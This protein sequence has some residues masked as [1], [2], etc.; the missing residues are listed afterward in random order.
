[1]L[2]GIVLER[3]SEQSV[4]TATVGF[5]SFNPIGQLGEEFS[6]RFALGK[7]EASGGR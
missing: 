7:T 2:V 5:D 1:M 3:D 6:L 4:F